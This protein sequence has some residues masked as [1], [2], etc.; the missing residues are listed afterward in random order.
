[1]G[2]DLRCLV[3][4]G[5][6]LD[7]QD[8]A[9]VHA[10]MAAAFGMEMAGFR[11]RVFARAPLIIRRGL[12]DAT[13]QTQATQL[14]GMGAEADVWPD[15]ERL[16]WLRRDNQV[17]GPLPEEAL[18]QYGQAGDQWCHDGGQTWFAWALAPTD[19]EVVVK[20]EAGV[21]P[22]PPPLP[23]LLAAPLHDDT[24]TWASDEYAEAFPPD[25]RDDTA[26]EPPPLP[27]PVT[28]RPVK[29]PLSAAAVFTVLL[30]AAGL[31]WHVLSP[32]AL[33][34]AL[35]ALVYL[36][37]RP[38][39]RGRA[40]AVAAVLLSATGLFLW[41]PRPATVA[42]AQPYVARPLKPL[43][44]AAATAQ[45]MA[46]TASPK[47]DEDRFLLTGERLLT[48]RAQRKGDTYV[49]EAAVSVDQQ[50]QPSAL[51]LYVFRNGV[52]IGT[53]L[54]TAASVASTKLT[55]FDLVDDQHLRVTLAQCTD[56]LASCAA[57]SVRQF[58]VMPGGGGWTL[59]E[60]K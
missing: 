17:R 20:A 9:T 18:N 37:Q 29:K 40:I 34:L 56:K 31:Y 10:R 15:S 50:C 21:E 60:M 35:C 53:A 42:V 4:S 5:R 30:A 7:G 57:T 11:E 1:M 23:V 43:S 32:F 13:A 51:Q 2:M 6:L 41:M 52:F 48:G 44:G 16:V 33:L 22:E 8:P 39:L 27:T 36:H 59:G 47:N 46:R 28:A 25:A 55:D 3:L 49:A 26:A 19:A 12:E 14:R 24:D 58:A 45:C 54:D 38:M